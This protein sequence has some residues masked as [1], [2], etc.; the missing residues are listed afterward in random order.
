MFDVDATKL[1]NCKEVKELKGR[2]DRVGFN[3]PHVGQGITDQDRNVRANQTL[4]LNFFRSVA[5]FLKVGTSSATD[6]RIIK[7]DLS[8][9]KK[10]EKAHNLAHHTSKRSRPVESDDEE[11]EINSDAE[12]DMD[13]D[14]TTTKI[15]SAIPSS[16]T[17][18]GTVLVTLRTISP[19]SLWSLPHLATRG[20]LLL[21]SILPKPL[22]KTPQPSYLVLRSF[23]FNPMDYEGY[24]HRRTIGF[25]EGVS[26]GKNEDL[27]LSARERG[28]KRRQEKEQKER[29]EREKN[30]KR[31]SGKALI[32][33]WEFELV[34]PKDE[35]DMYD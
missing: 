10:K 27:E 28:E 6:Q 33:T 3:F 14:M 19:Y 26:S 8:K 7:S 22:P 20:P 25:K 30:G 4:L 13:Q 23:E 2:W 9:K 29:E 34:Q 18:S 1:E 31:G 15:P 16:P 5:P 35:D 32:R 12:M 21:P 17:T 24:E 11:E